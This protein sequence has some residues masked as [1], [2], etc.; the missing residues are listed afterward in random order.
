MNN[1]IKCN[2]RVKKPITIRGITL[3]FHRAWRWLNR[4]RSGANIVNY[5]PLHKSIQRTC[6]TESPADRI[7]EYLGVKSA[8]TSTDSSTDTTT[9]PLADSPLAQTQSKYFMTGT[10]VYCS[11]GATRQSITVEIIDKRAHNVR[12]IRS[13][14]PF[15]WDS[16]YLVSAPAN[17]FDRGLRAAH[18]LCQWQYL[19]SV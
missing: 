2:S 13:W 19:H 1:F 12:T 3:V 7:F 15:H 8:G 14:S 10:S 5:L 6:H 4:D 11:I 17:G 16:F 9:D 18:A